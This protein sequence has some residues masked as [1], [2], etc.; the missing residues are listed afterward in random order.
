METYPMMRASHIHQ[1]ISSRARLAAEPRR[2]VNGVV[3][4]GRQ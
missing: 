4:G 1:A 3:I 2:V